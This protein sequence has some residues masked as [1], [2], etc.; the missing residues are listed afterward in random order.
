MQMITN[1][2][3]FAEFTSEQ[4]MDIIKITKACFHYYKVVVI[5]NPNTLNNNS[6]TTITK[7]TSNSNNNTNNTSNSNNN[8]NNTSNSN[9]NTNNTSN[10]KEA[11]YLYQ[12]LIK[13]KF[14][15]WNSED[16]WL[17]WYETEVNLEMSNLYSTENN[18]NSNNSNNSNNLTNLN[19]E[20]T[21]ST[22]NTNN[23]DSNFF[24]SQ[25]EKNTDDFYFS[26]VFPMFSVMKD[27]H[28]EPNFVVNII[29][30]IGVKYIVQEFLREELQ[31][32]VLKQL[33][34]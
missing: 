3:V 27:L 25:I 10:T 31:K 11:Y 9:N 19:N 20:N 1:S 33:K 12:E 15:V 8:T 28:L 26:K 34:K 13:Q 32:T 24:N 30:R 22:N 4:L 6:T 16:L 7:N 29:N 17:S 14:K 2:L 5:G 23:F 18:S 21:N